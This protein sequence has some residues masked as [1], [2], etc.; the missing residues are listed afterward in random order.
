M[1]V[2]VQSKRSGVMVG[3]G[4]RAADASANSLWSWPTLLIALCLSALPAVVRLIYYPGYLGTDD[5]FIHAAV[6][7]SLRA[8][9][10]WGINPGEPV[11]ISTS[12]LFTL[13]MLAVSWVVPDVML[14]GSR[15]AT[16]A[17]MF[18]VFGTFVIASRMSGSAAIGL[19]AGAIA[20]TNVH[21]WRWTGTFIE[22]PLAF[23][24]VIGVLLAFA[25]L[26][27]GQVAHPALGRFFALGLSISVLALLRFECALLGPA[28]L[29]HHLVNDR[30]FLL[31]RYAAAALGGAVPLAIWGVAAWSMFGSILP[32][33]LSAKTSAGII[34]L[35]PTLIEQ[36]ASV[37]GP[38]FL[39]GIV[40]LAAALIVLLSRGQLAKGISAARQATLF[41]A[42]AVAGLA[43]YYL[44]TPSLQSPAR[45]LLPM[46][47]VL[48]LAITP[49][50]AQAWQLAGNWLRPAAAAAV[51]LQLVLAAVVNHT[52]V[53]PVL[54]GMN[55]AYVE[56][57]REV[58]QELDRR[59]TSSDVVLVE[60]DIG[61]VSYYH[62]HGCRIADGGALASPE[63]RGLSVQE[64]LA[65]VRPRYVIESL[66][67]PDRS[68]VAITEPR[69]REV[70]SR[71]FA[72]HSVGAPE[73]LY[74][75]RLFE[76]D[77]PEPKTWPNG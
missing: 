57:M 64:K 6:I 29:L 1:G 14:A 7:E 63:L 65:A 12:P 11:N 18:G 45:Y 62:R 46:M 68:D 60:F 20:A 23:A 72:S 13:L 2:A 67:S 59:C 40:L 52:R 71:L 38:G 31:R 50:I 21:L 74:R 51:A 77:R 16:A 4:S 17:V 47:A 37:L 35:N 42:F 70:W 26:H 32:T 33:T 34:L 54:A 58:A 5:S 55:D 8:G 41:I 30:S 76:L 10:G 48:P 53:A 36:Y 61:V 39:A 3:A 24:A 56:A 75:A 73:R 22:A 43:F 28:F 66:G 27:T 49:F 9:H 19:V 44:K 69:A 25:R 15:L